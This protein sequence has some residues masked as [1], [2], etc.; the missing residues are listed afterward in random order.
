MP[1]S[2]PVSFLV[3]DELAQLYQ[4]IILD[5]YRN[6]RHRA[7]LVAEEV[8][9]EGDNPL[10]GDQ[11]KFSVRIEGDHIVSVRHDGR[12]CAISQASASILSESVHGLTLSAAQYLLDTSLAALRGE[13]LWPDTLPTDLQALRGVS[14][15]PLRIKCA[16]LP[17]HTLKNIFDRKKGSNA[18]C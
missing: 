9:G 8:D 3:M 1:S 4:D 12:G 2:G 18:K 11:I 17:F 15:Y 14:A 6:P 16:T 13:M 7:A 10:C 5:H